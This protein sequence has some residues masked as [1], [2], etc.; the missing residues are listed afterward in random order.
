MTNTLINDKGLSGILS[1]WTVND[2][3]S[4]NATGINP[5]KY[6]ITEILDLI[7]EIKQN[8]DPDELEELFILM[9]DHIH[10]NQ[11]PHEL[12]LESLGTSVIAELYAE[13]LSRGYIGTAEE[14]SDVLFQY[15]TI[16]SI[17][18][19]REGLSET[20]LISVKGA[21]ILYDDHLTDTDA[22]YELFRAMMPGTPIAQIPLYSAH[23]FQGVEKDMIVERDD[24]CYYHLPTGYLNVV[25]ADTLAI[26]HIHND[27]MYSIWGERT[28]QA[29]QSRFFTEGEFLGGTGDNYDG[30]K[31]PLGEYDATLLTD[32]NDSVI[33]EHGWRSGSFSV[34]SG[35][36]YT[37]SL[38]VLPIDKRYFTITLPEAVA[39]PA[40]RVYDLLDEDVVYEPMGYDSINNDSELIFLHNKY[41]RVC[42][43]F[44]AKTTM[45]CT[46]KALFLDVLNGDTTYMGLGSHPGVIWQFQFEEGLGASPVIF[47]TDEPVTRAAT[48]VRIPFHDKF[49]KD[50]GTLSITTIKPM[51]VSQPEP[52][53]LYS[54]SAT[55][56]GLELIFGN[57]SFDI[58][59]EGVPDYYVIGNDD[60][61]NYI[62]EHEE[63]ARIVSDNTSNVLI[64]RDVDVLPGANLNWS[65]TIG[66][67]VNGL[68]RYSVYDVT[69]GSDI[70]S[71]TNITNSDNNGI[72]D[73]DFVV[74]AGCTSVRLIIMRYDGGPTDYVIK[75]WSLESDEPLALPTN[76]LSSTAHV[77]I[78]NYPTLH[79]Q[80]LYMESNNVFEA[81]LSYSWSGD[82]LRRTTTYVHSYVPTEHVYANT[83]DEPI[84]QPIAGISI[85]TAE[86]I[87]YV[88]YDL[89]NMEELSDSP[90]IIIDFENPVIASSVDLSTL[91][92]S[93]IL[94][95]VLSVTYKNIKDNSEDYDVAAVDLL[96]ESD[97][98]DTLTLY[99]FADTLHVGCDKNNEHFLNGYVKDIVYYTTGS[100][101]MNAE[102]LIG[103]YNDGE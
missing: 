102:F 22:H 67:H 13:W 30:A 80:R 29:L 73:V 96:E 21:K 47:T 16:A 20:K 38:Y 10:N 41:V 101:S 19:T 87:D 89:W 82:A 84:V 17:E 45:T 74:P 50:R 1:D 85:T 86:A 75:D 4:Q 7:R 42:H 34:E 83:G 46:I 78:G 12:T 68:I 88:L 43:S 69:N 70:I 3:L 9:E 8:F 65:I 52:Q 39:G 60:V 55:Y 23:A 64:R 98:S 100:S 35:K 6:T 94:D 93:E 62:E 71:Y 90:V 77:I 92:E 95:I 31:S 27:P 26:D 51:N 59:E 15:V 2:D 33:C 79:G 57:R 97:L 61:N 32:A 11:N 103:E 40:Y 58:W 14:F 18:E 99:D 44:R 53:Y 81:P 36:V 48:K 28:N 63:G 56:R 49:D 72:Y 66:E 91:T 37:I 25:P 54:L 24:E 5:R 76:T